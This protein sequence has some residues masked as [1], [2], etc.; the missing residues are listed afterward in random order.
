LCF[1][2]EGNKAGFEKSDQPEKPVANEEE[3]EAKGELNEEEEEA[4]GELHEESPGEDINPEGKAGD[5]G[6]LTPQI[7][8]IK[9][10]LAPGTSNLI[11]FNE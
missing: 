6:T 10:D 1:K 8:S 2:D 9:A 4:K 11:L 3:D 5:R 7:S